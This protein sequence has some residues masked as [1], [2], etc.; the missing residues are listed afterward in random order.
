MSFG[1]LVVVDV[2]HVL[3]DDGDTE[4]FP[5]VLSVVASFP[6]SA[7]LELVSTFYFFLNLRRDRC[8]F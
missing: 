5:L 1:L 4:F 7:S 8:F 2:G 3:I 6:V